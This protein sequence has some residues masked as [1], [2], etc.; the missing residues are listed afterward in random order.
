MKKILLISFISTSLFTQNI[1]T[2]QTIIGK[3]E[4]K[5]N[6]KIITVIAGCK[7]EENDILMTKTK[8]SMTVLLNDGKL[9][10]LG[11]KTLLSIS[12]YLS[13]SIEK[14]DKPDVNESQEQSIEFDTLFLKNYFETTLIAVESNNASV[15][16]EP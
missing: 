13:T 10:V 3:V 2:I 9:L 11:S 15:E 5:R 12:K 8:S 1:G 14:R 6:K 16:V 4:V 7:L